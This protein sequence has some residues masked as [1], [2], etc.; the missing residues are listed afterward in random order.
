LSEHKSETHQ[1]PG[2]FEFYHLGQ[3]KSHEAQSAPK[4]KFE[5]FAQAG[6]KFLSFRVFTDSEERPWL[7]VLG[8]PQ[9]LESEVYAEL[10]NVLAS[11]V[12]NLWAKE[13]GQVWLVSPPSTAQTSVIAE[14]LSR[15][16]VVVAQTYI[17]E[18]EL[19][20]EL[21]RVPLLCLLFPIRETQEEGHA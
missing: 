5:A 18:Q 14:T 11:Q 10:G 19:A 7:M 13:K 15:E 6:S 21:Y 9:A 4:A 16:S 8:F 2:S 17:H 12:A 3:V 1:F 20:G